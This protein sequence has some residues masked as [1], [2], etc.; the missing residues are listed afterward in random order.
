M[1]REFLHA[2]HPDGKF[3]TSDFHVKQEGRAADG[4]KIQQFEAVNP[5]VNH[6]YRHGI[7]VQKP[8]N[9]PLMV[10]GSYNEIQDISSAI[11]NDPDKV[12]RSMRPI[13]RSQFFS[14][15]NPITNTKTHS[16]PT[17]D[18]AR[19]YID[20]KRLFPDH[21]KDSQL[22]SDEQVEKRALK[23]HMQIVAESKNPFPKSSAEG[24]EWSNNYLKVGTQ[25]P[26]TLLTDGGTKP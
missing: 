14:L 15:N 5:A 26:S 11:K 24:Q 2:I 22:L 1:K 3:R 13:G 7:Q 9:T 25:S 20:A 19:S 6:S 4:T 21:G 10:F 16:A 8:G 17:E 23:Q 18:K 12:V